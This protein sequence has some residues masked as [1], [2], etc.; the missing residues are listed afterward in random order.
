MVSVTVFIKEP[1][2]DHWEGLGRREF[3]V[4]PRVG[5]HIGDA[6]YL[7]RVVSMQ[8]PLNP[9]MTAGDLYAVQV[10]GFADSAKGSLR[11]SSER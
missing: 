9:T 5:E 4:L 3:M 8:H 2:G 6:T 7:Y 11:R 10:G 1:G